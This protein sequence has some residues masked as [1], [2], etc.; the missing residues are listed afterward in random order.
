MSSIRVNPLQMPDLLAA[1]E[2]LQR[3]QSNITLELA[4]G[5]SINQP[6]D[7]PAGAAQIVK[8]NDLSSQ[9]DSFQRSI[10]SISGQFSTAD[11]T[12][13]SV[14][15]AL[16]RAISLGVEGANG[17]LSDADRQA[18]A[19]ELTGIQSQ[20]LSL[21]NTSYQGQYIFAGTATTAP[22]FVVDA[23]QPS[24]IRYVGNAGTNSVTIG[25]GYQLQVNLSGSQIFNGTGGDVF[26][27]INDLITSLK[28]NTGIG[29]A[30]TELRNAFSYVTGQRVFYG[31][32]LNQTQS[33][34]TYLNTETLSL[35]QQLNTVGG[36]NIA[37]VAS[38]LVN[39]QTAQ[40]ATL[41]AIGKTSQS[42]LFDFLK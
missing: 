15:T 22:P 32:A 5:S 31:N 20:L 4:T 23:T 9:V 38:Q 2:Q 10:S 8:I 14:V 42:N 28:S 21:A 36:A 26:L 34:Q 29:A 11:S 41:E 13:N 7:N 30:V 37:D 17:T 3:Q 19:V 18:I 27:A 24:G 1:L 12:L 25:S 40:T 35:S 6:S 33:Q 39:D 16:Q